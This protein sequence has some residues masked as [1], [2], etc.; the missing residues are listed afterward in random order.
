MNKRLAQCSLWF[1]RRTAFLR[2]RAGLVILAVALVGL[3]LLWLHVQRPAHLAANAA[4]YGS[5]R[6]F[7]G[8]AWLNHDGSQ[9]IYVAPANDRGHAVI[10]ANTATGRKRQI[11]E[12]KQGVGIWNDEF[13]AQAGPWSPDDS[14][15]LCRV[16][17]R[18]MLCSAGT[19][20]EN[21]VIDDRPFSSEAAWLTPTRFAYV[22][23]QTD[24]C[25]GEKR[26]DG[27]WERKLILSRKAPLTALTAIGSDMVAWLEDG[28]VIWRVDL[29]GG[30]S[31]GDAPSPN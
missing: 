1:W 2:S 22:T 21:V 9:L 27:H 13:N 7:Y 24:L 10:L 23:D 25:L 26:A 28:A 29:S 30:G 20:Q 14:C 18:L 3:R 11:I 5:V 17:N 12:D 6:R 8:P 31:G 4:A 19:N 15:F 16:G